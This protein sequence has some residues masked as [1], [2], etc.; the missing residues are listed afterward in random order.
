MVKE[1]WGKKQYSRKSDNWIILA[2]D[3]V[4]K[5]GE[6][7]RL[8][9][10]YRL[11]G[12]QISNVS[13]SKSIGKFQDMK[14]SSTVLYQYSDLIYRIWYIDLVSKCHCEWFHSLSYFGMLFENLTSPE[15][16]GCWQI[17]KSVGS[18]FNTFYASYN[19]YIHHTSYNTNIHSCNVTIFS[20]NF[21]IY[22]VAGRQFRT[23]LRQMLRIQSS[24][25]ISEV[26]LI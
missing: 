20:V 5:M 26:S 17:T 7:N 16:Y 10:I 13:S 1:S 14:F 9:A 15:I 2:C 4:L 11:K 3:E 6:Q 21:L 24:P 23:G 22:C 18:A 8:E 19:T 25:R 12:Y